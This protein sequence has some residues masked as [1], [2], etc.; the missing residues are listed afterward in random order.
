MSKAVQQ[1]HRQRLLQRE[2]AVPRARVHQVHRIAAIVAAV[3]AA[4]VVVVVG[5]ALA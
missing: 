1:R 4:I 3:A 5:A 2:E